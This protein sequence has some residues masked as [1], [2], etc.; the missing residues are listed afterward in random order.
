MKPSFIT[1]PLVLAWFG[2][3][4]LGTGCAT[5]R[6]QH[7]AVRMPDLPD[8]PGLP[9]TDNTYYRITYR[10]GAEAET[11]TTKSFDQRGEWLVMETFSM[12][13]VQV[14]TDIEPSP[15]WLLGSEVVSIQKKTMETMPS[16]AE[17]AAR[18][19]AFHEA[20]QDSLRRQKEA[21]RPPQPLSGTIPER[22]PQ[23]PPPQLPPG[24]VPSEQP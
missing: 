3:V 12:F 9:D 6:S 19:E 15:F 14:R 22:A 20:F 10:K 7:S 24:N 2:L 23:L 8:L 4:V 11:V 17:R 1:I 5:S 13:N 16:P 18:S 21:L